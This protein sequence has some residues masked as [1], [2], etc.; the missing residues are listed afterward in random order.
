MMRTKLHRVRIC[1]A[2][3]A[4]AALPA[5]SQHDPADPGQSLAEGQNVSTQALEAMER[6]R[7][8]LN[9]L[10]RFE[11][12][13]QA[14]RDELLPYGY[15]LQNN[16]SARM[17]VQRPNRFRID[18]DGDLKHRSYYYD[19]AALTMVAQDEG[20]YARTDAPDTIARVVNGLLN[21][22]VELPMID[23]LAHGFQGTL[24]EGVRYGL[25]VDETSLGGTTTEHL[26]FRQ[27]DIDWQIWIAEEGQPR[28]LVIT[29]RY[30]VGNPQYQAT[31]Q[32]NVRPR[33]HA[34]TFAYTPAEGMRE[35]SF[36]SPPAVEEAATGGNP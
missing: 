27:P 20:V 12:T 5:L 10:D 13:M 4:M 11:V 1:G 8:F 29:T 31:M 6:M 23:V 32:W 19:G 25:V 30:E 33:I 28:K 26:A 15:K 36:Y 9:G 14:S 17:L 16:E 21:A 35:I 22:G 3:L 24:L 34:D 7:G 18:V 2:A